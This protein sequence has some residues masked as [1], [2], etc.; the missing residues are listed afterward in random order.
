MT[1]S[2]VRAH[3]RLGTPALVLP[4]AR[5]RH[6]SAAFGNRRARSSATTELGDRFGA[7]SRAARSSLPI[8]MSARGRCTVVTSISIRRTI[9]FVELP[10]SSRTWRIPAHGV[11]PIAVEARFRARDGGRPRVVVRGPTRLYP[12]GSAIGRARALNAAAG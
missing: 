10:R 1:R 4:G 8:R 12:R 11:V 9:S 5:V 6:A 3:E 2:A 7:A